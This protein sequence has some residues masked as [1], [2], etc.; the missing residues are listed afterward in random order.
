MSEAS[1]PSAH[2]EG[3]WQQDH[4]DEVSWFQ[5]GPTVSLE[6]AARVTDPSS[7]IIDVGGGASR[8]AE[9]LLD[10]G[11]TDITVLDLAS[12]AVDAGRQRLGHREGDVRWLVEDVTTWKPGRMF[13]LWHDRAVLHFL[14]EQTDRDRYVATLRQVTAPG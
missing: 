1:G 7:S 8:L 5:T 6:L 10:A 11:Y 9:G 4:L 12:A 14:A 3:L 13:D 2:W